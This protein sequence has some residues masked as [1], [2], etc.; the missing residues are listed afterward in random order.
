MK[1]LQ[2]HLKMLLCLMVSAVMLFTCALVG[3]GE[4]SAPPVDEDPPTVTPGPG[5]KDPDD[6]EPD[7]KELHHAAPYHVFP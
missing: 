2:K 7:D 4:Q 1:K 5:D 3:C 6:K